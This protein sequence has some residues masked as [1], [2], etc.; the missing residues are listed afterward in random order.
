MKTRAILCAFAIALLAAGANAGEER[1]LH[2][3]VEERGEAGETVRINLPFEL[4]E[5]VLETIRTDEMS[6]GKIRIEDQEIETEE[7]RKILRAV[8]EAREGEYISVEGIDEDVRVTKKGDFLL[9]RAREEVEGST[10]PET[11]DIRLHLSV[12]DALASGEGE[13][14]DVLAAI[15]ALGTSGEGE[16]VVVNEEDSTVRIWI[17]ADPSGGVR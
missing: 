13:E 8:R 15:R 17:D 12:L 16:I 2:V 7:I 6:G 4:V 10:I 11:V 9:V 5:S 1:W 3:F 14:L